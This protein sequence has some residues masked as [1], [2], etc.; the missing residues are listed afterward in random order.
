MIAVERDTLLDFDAATG[1]EWLETNGLGGF[2]SSTVIGLNTR[3]Y[4]G[5]LIAAT[6]PPA[7]RVVLLSKCEETLI[8]DSRRYD[9]ATNA[10]TGAVHPQGHQY[11]VRFRPNP[12]PVF[13]FSCGGI[14]LEKS[15]FMSHGTN[16]TVI[17]YRLIQGNADD[18]D[19]ELRPLVAFRD[20]HS[21]THENG[22]ID[23]RV[24]VHNE[25]L[26]SFR[27]YGDRPSLYFAH[28]G[29]L[30]EEPG[31]WY[32]NFEY[33]M[34]RD[35]GLDFHEDLF[36]PFALRFD[37]KK[38]SDASLIASTEAAVDIASVD[39]MRLK[40]VRRRTEVVK[41]APARD[42]LRRAL[43]AAADQYIVNRDNHKT[44]V[45]GYHW[46]ADWGRDTMIALP[47]LTL[48]T[49]RYDVA[50]SILT[51]FARYVDQGMLPN[52]FSDS[53]EILEYNTIDATLWYFEAIRSLLQYT[54]DYEF[55]R[56]YLFSILTSI[57]EW[58][59]RGTR[60]GIKM[61]DDGLIASNDPN[62]QLTWMDAKIGDHVVTPR[63][64]KAVEIQALWY[65][66]LRTMQDIAAKLGSNET[67]EK[68][69]SIADL[70]RRSF[71]ALFWNE[72]SGCLYDTVL[73][74]ERDSSIRP[75]QILAVS[76]THSMLERDRAAQVVDV[77]QRHLF[78]PYGLR[79]LSPSDSRYRGSYEGDAAT[80]DSS[81]HQGPAW[82]WLLGPF[83]SAYLK[84]NQ[85]RNAAR[86]TARRWLT[87]FSTHL[88]EA[89]LG[90]VSELFDGDPPHRPRGCVAQAWSVAEVLRAAA[91]LAQTS[92]IG[93]AASGRR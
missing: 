25:N 7:G 27:A 14:E 86:D 58:H 82:A 49:G 80:R 89:C 38:R 77:V 16:T 32:R 23:T 45:A 75:N 2:A 68:Y 41:A 47:G 36:N 71:N 26:L 92:K 50:R 91:E 84:V 28:H 34:E 21:L 64:G 74:D 65:N 15:V 30:L 5:L 88:N 13:T 62:V 42:K 10:Y 78:T 46:F 67:A 93:R 37:L 12:F 44:I 19:L 63:S 55:V 90:Q 57:I 9:L 35:R 51:E 61:D 70:A 33:A 56:I 76:L 43:T 53:G 39:S 69:S 20:Y 83:I 40:E 18:I 4:H 8:I 87:T 81:Y 85:N 72:E 48:V 29:A 60:F 66:A 3:R 59:L 6:R 52:R 1:L 79:T 54:K 24:D 22:A 31:Y 11:L 73:D 17:Q